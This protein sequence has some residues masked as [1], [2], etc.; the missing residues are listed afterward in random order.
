MKTKERASR[1]T[2]V[3]KTA[4]RGGNRIY[5]ITLEVGSSIV[6]DPSGKILRIKEIGPDQITFEQL[7]VETTE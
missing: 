5:D 7:D 4:S 1:K 3:R 6:I 2:P